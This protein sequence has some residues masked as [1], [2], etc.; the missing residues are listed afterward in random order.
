MGDAGDGADGPIAG[1]GDGVGNA[2]AGTGPS[3][4]GE[5]A[6]SEDARYNAEKR[7][8]RMEGNA[9]LAA[10]AR[11]G[12][13]EYSRL[14]KEQFQFQF[15]FQFQIQISLDSSALEKREGGRVYIDGGR[16]RATYRRG[17]V[18][19]C[20]LSLRWVAPENEDGGD[21][22]TQASNF[23]FRHLADDYLNMKEFCLLKIN[24]YIIPELSCAD[25][26][27]G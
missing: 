10:M 11:S 26:L 3:G 2:G 17:S 5:V 21:Y 23:S 25:G 6:I 19:H 27:S 15:Q 8:R 18:I 4:S 1:A 7:R 22:P 14:D 13:C 12:R 9:G 20:Q 16:R 24:K